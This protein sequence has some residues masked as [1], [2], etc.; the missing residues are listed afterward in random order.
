[1]LNREPNLKSLALEAL[2]A[3]EKL[4]EQFNI[5]EEQLNTIFDLAL[6]KA[7]EAEKI[8]RKVASA[9]NIVKGALFIAKPLDESDSEI[10]IQ[11]KREEAFV[12]TLAAQLKKFEKKE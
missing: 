7:D 12:K 8:W 6:Q 5:T 3:K 1:M 9:S 2:R 10:M 4:L 11:Q